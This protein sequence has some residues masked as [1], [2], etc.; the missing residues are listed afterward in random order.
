MAPSSPAFTVEVNQQ[1]DSVC[2]DWP[3][4]RSRGASLERTLLQN[5]RSRNRT[6]PKTG[7]GR[8]CSDCYETLL[9]NCGEVRKCHRESEGIFYGLCAGRRPYTS[10]ALSGLPGRADPR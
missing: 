5:L 4:A 2:M 1:A 10:N 9:K 7:K 3:D 8:M 6:S